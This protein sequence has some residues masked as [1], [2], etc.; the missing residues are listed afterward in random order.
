MFSVCQKTHSQWIFSKHRHGALI[1]TA[2]PCFGVTPSSVLMGVFLFNTPSP[3]SGKGFSLVCYIFPIFCHIIRNTLPCLLPL[4]WSRSETQLFQR[5][6]LL[7]CNSQQLWERRRRRSQRGWYHSS[8][9]LC[10]PDILSYMTI[11]LKEMTVLFVIGS[12]H[13][14]LHWTRI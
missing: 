9:A 13:F 14:F 3:P 2:A 12:S 10:V 6:D 8:A 7:Y 11:I 5:D 4:I 1:C